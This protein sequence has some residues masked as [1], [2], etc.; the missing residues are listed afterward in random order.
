MVL[1]RRLAEKTPLPSPER[2]VL[3]KTKRRQNVTHRG[4]RNQFLPE[5]DSFSD[6]IVCLLVFRSTQPPQCRWCAEDVATSKRLTRKSSSSV[7]KWVEKRSSF[8]RCL[9]AQTRWFSEGPPCFSFA[10]FISCTGKGGSRGKSREEVRIF[11]R[12]VLQDAGCGREELLHQGNA[13]STLTRHC[14][15]ERWK[16]VEFAG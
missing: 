7:R 3:S 8:T 11:H 15:L 16:C 14:F 13:G 12:Q 10:L 1:K 4:N 9:W 2:L 6:S 5:L